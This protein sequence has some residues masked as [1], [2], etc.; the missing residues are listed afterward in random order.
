VSRKDYFASEFVLSRD[1]GAIR[2]WVAH[3]FR[4]LVSASRRNHLFKVYDCE[5][6]SPTRET[7]ALPGQCAKITFLCSSSSLKIDNQRRATDVC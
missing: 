4:A 1:L 7:R 5:T 6:Q 3:P 2:F